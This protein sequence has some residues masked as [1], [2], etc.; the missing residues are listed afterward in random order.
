MTVVNVPQRTPKL[1]IDKK[2]VKLTAKQK[3]QQPVSLLTP[4]EYE[5]DQLL[6]NPDSPIK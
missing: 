3:E 6:L 2:A 4:G 1:L 5:D